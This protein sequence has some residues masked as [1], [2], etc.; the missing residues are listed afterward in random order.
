MPE[1]AGVLE[2]QKRGRSC[3]EGD[4]G[5]SAKVPQVFSPPTPRQA[6]VS[7]NKDQTLDKS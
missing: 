6:G 1:N 2:A 4:E 5:G 7:G 3:L